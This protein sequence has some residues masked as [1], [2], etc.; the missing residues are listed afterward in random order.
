MES[1]NRL[2]QNTGNRM[3]LVL[4][5]I[6][7]PVLNL[8]IENAKSEEAMLSVLSGPCLLGFILR[9]NSNEVYCTHG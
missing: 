4:T 8:K 6:S 2:T 9:R 7:T 3:V 1:A 5:I